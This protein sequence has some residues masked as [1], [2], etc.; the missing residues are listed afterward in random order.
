MTALFY[1]KLGLNNP[2]RVSRKQP[3]FGDTLQELTLTP[4][5]YSWAL[6]QVFCLHTTLLLLDIYSIFKIIIKKI[7]DLMLWSQRQVCMIN[8]LFDSPEFSTPTGRLPNTKFQQHKVC[9]VDGRPQHER[10]TANLHDWHGVRWRYVSWNDVLVMVQMLVLVHFCAESQR[11]HAR[12]TQRQTV[13]TE[14]STQDRHRS[15]SAVLQEPFVQSLLNPEHF[16][17]WNNRKK[18]K[19]CA[20]EYN[21]QLF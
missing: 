6:E 14:V 11:W 15:Q 3:T 18:I 17:V 7:L 10:S 20:E 2:L 1:A 8:Q 19:N 13:E 5:V 12:K 9:K 16:L 21:C 4:L